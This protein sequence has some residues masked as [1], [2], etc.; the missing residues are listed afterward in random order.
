[1]TLGLIIGIII[2]LLVAGFILWAGRKF[3]SVVEM[4]D[5]IRKVVDVLL[6]VLAAAIILFGVVI[7]LLQVLANIH[8]PMPKIG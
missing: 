4:D 7:P 1:M 2:W 8:I 5:S 3:I 6:V